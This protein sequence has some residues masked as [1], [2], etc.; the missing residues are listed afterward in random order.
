[1]GKFLHGTLLA[2]GSLVAFI[3]FGLHYLACWGITQIHLSLEGL[4]VG[5]PDHL[6]MTMGLIFLTLT[7]ALGWCCLKLLV[8][9]CKMSANGYAEFFKEGTP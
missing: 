1:M 9:G 2:M 3:D 5:L 4:K 8:L 6:G 7:I